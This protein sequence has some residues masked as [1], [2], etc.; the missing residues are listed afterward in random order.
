MPER[1][2]VA[3]PPA[4]LVHGIDFWEIGW[5]RC[6]WPLTPIVPISDFK[7]CGQPVSCGSWCSVHA[8]RAHRD[9]QPSGAALAPVRAPPQ[10]TLAPAPLPTAPLVV[11]LERC[12]I[13]EARELVTQMLAA[14][15]L[16]DRVGMWI[17]IE[18]K[19]RTAAVGRRRLRALAWEFISSADARPHV[20][21]VHGTGSPGQ[22]GR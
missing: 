10:P 17:K 2:N 14:P 12:G 20:D 3:K 13:E 9:R 4:D 6:R 5:D 1:R 18:A 16:S 22:A 21:L 19:L 8:D 11:A 15:R 7:F